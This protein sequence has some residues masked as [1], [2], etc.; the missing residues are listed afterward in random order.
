MTYRDA[1]LVVLRNSRRAMTATEIAD[2]ALKKGL[3]TT[4]GRTP[5][6]TMSAALYLYTRDVEDASIRREFKPGLIRAR[7]ESVRWTLNQRP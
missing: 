5:G 4:R 3:I 7:R 1:A 2:A 6:Q